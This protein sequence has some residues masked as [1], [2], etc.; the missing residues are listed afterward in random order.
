MDAFAERGDHQ[1]D[2]HQDGEPSHHRRVP[3]GLKKD[4]HVA[5]PPK[6]EAAV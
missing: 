5:L 3:D 2:R 6:A 1:D 4:V